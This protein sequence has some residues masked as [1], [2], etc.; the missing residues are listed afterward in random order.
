VYSG[1]VASVVALS[2]CSVMF[3]F[4]VCMRASVKL[5]NSMFSNITRATM[6]FFN[7]N[8]SGIIDMLGYILTCFFMSYHIYECL[9]QMERYTQMLSIYLAHHAGVYVCYCIYKS[10]AHLL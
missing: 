7:S 8:S 6:W 9:I 3:F 1:L 10:E 2:V 5:H 4:T